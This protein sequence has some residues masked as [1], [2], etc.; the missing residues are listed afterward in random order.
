M[1]A[2][3]WLCIALFVIISVAGLIVNR[4]LAHAQRRRYGRVRRWAEANGWT[5]VESPQVNW[6]DRLPGGGRVTLLLSGVVEGRS[7]AVGEYQHTHP[8][9]TAS[10]E[11]SRHDTTT[12]SYVVAGV[13]LDR[14]YAPFSLHKTDLGEKVLRSIVGRST[15][16]LGYGPFDRKHRIVAA[17]PADIP[18]YLTPPLVNDLTA[19]VAPLWSIQDTELIVYRLGTIDPSRIPAAATEAIRMAQVLRVA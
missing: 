3:T 12:T 18:R 16:P 1:S 11:H 5:V 10:R 4:L 19:G 9:V 13:R 17:N 14:R 8:S 2:S 7:V 6:P 15:V